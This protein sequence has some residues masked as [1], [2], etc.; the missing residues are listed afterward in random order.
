MKDDELF[1]KI[2]NLKYVPCDT[3]GTVLTQ[4]YENQV[5]GI[6]LR[7]TLFYQKSEVATILKSIKIFSDDKFLRNHIMDRISSQMSSKNFSP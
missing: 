1:Y 6:G 4:L 2:L 5:I 7:I 3:R